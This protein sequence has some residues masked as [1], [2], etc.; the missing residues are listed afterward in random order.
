M[1]NAIIICAVALLIGGLFASRY[2]LAAD[3][4]AKQTPQQMAS[5]LA[6]DSN[7]MGFNLFRELSNG[8]KGNVFFSPTSLN[9]ALGMTYNGAA[10]QTATGIAKAM[11]LG[12]LMPD[13]TN[14][15][16]KAL[17]DM[18]KKA[19]PSVELNIVN[20]I[21][22][23]NKCLVLPAF[24]DTNKAAYG[25]EIANMDLT[26]PA[27]AKPINEW[28]AKG[29]K[30]KINNLLKPG[31]FNIN[32]DMVLANAVYF[33]GRWTHPFQEDMTKDGDF[34]LLDGTMKKVSM[35]MQTGF[36]NYLEDDKVQM[37]ALPYGWKKNL[38]MNI[39]LPGTAVK[40][41]DIP[42]L[43]TLDNW[44][45]WNA[46]AQKVTRVELHLPRI[47]TSYQ[48][49]LND[50]LKNLGMVDAFTEKADFSKISGKKGLYISFVRHQATLD[51]DEQGTEATAATATDFEH[52]S[53]V[54]LDK[55]IK[56]MI[57]DRPFFVVINDNQTG[58]ILFMGYIKDP[59][60]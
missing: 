22:V 60:A 17:L 16:N 54:Q 37:I 52:Q 38:H 34:T 2:L 35:M 29:T 32:T 55:E 10:G 33:K 27:A 41:E 19:D 4:A 5:V 36:F 59:Q 14:M 21:W 28:I 43:F 30:N 24:I 1:R 12:K 47:N 39:I 13:D 9:M 46:A 42:A 57:V 50:S 18:L 45:K 15:G 3:P 23:D 53:V 40:A 11:S 8:E 20:G 56:K 31:D 51:L 48:Q 26:T 6:G 44:N 25:A 49:T 58:A 7:Q